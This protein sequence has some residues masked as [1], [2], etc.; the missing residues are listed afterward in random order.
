MAVLVGYKYPLASE[1][2]IE[3]LLAQKEIRSMNCYPSDNSIKVIDG[4][5]VVKLNEEGL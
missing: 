2:T 3:K 1:E 5:L 4:T